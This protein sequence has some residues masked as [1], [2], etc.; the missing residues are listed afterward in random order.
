MKAIFLKQVKYAGND[1]ASHF[2]IK[3]IFLQKVVG[4]QVLIAIACREVYALRVLSAETRLT[5][6]HR[7]DIFYD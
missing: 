1:G 3:E 7:F 2:F 6:Y 4:Q 5:V